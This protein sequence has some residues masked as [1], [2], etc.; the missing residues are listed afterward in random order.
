MKGHSNLRTQTPHIS[1]K[2]KSG[3]VKNTTVVQGCDY[4][5]KLSGDT[6][7]KIPPL[8]RESEPKKSALGER[9][10]PV[11]RKSVVALSVREALRAVSR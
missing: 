1:T 3:Q 6:F 8:K 7:V 2:F 5:S 4:L 11:A 9:S 10:T